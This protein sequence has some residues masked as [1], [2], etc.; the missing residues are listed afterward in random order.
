MNRNFAEEE[1]SLAIVLLDQHGYGD[2]IS[3]CVL[4]ILQKVN[5]LIRLLHIGF[6]KVSKDRAQV[7]FELGIS[8][9]ENDSHFG[10][11]RGRVY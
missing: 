11:E 8:L 4:F 5:S 6:V 10:Q 1:V 3:D 9:G 2:R 7:S